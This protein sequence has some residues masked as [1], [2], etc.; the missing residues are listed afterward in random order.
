MIVFRR[1]FR[2]EL[3]PLMSATSAKHNFHQRGL[4]FVQQETQFVSDVCALLI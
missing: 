3:P 4:G 1:F 2:C